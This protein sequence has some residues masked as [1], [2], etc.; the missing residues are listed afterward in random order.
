[1][2]LVV[3][4]TANTKQ[5]QTQVTSKSANTHRIVL[6]IDAVADEVLLHQQLLHHSVVDAWNWSLV[7]FNKLPLCVSDGRRRKC[8]TLPADLIKK[9]ISSAHKHHAVRYWTIAQLQG[10]F[11][12][13]IHLFLY[14]LQLQPSVR[15]YEPLSCELEPAL[16][17][18]H[19]E[20]V[21]QAVH[22]CFLRS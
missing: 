11:N 18:V 21:R 9:S 6:V 22:W 20:R 8:C 12:H 3:N 4:V 16:R 15:C 14:L 17:G 7:A 2:P 13:I 19:F 1:M 5:P 10:D